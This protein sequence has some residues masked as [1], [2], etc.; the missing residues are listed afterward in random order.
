MAISATSTQPREWN[1]GEQ[2]TSARLNSMIGYTE[3]VKNSASSAISNA[4]QANTIANEA[5]TLAQTAK[6][7]SRKYSSV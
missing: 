4:S 7:R 6:S 3:Y 5:K 2:I 1:E